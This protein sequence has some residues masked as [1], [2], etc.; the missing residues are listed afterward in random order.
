MEGLEVA[1]NV[2]FKPICKLPKKKNCRKKNCRKR[3]SL[4]LIAESGNAIDANRYI[5]NCL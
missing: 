1:K 4:P 3:S 5:D 2:K